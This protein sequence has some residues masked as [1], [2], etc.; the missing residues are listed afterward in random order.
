MLG[1]ESSC[2]PTAVPLQT[3]KEGRTMLKEYCKDLVA[4][5]RAGRLDPVIGRS[6]EVSRVI[7]V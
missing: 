1:S 3:D 4:E 7:Q 5:V 2:N 6:R